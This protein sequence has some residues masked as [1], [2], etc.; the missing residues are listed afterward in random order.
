MDRRVLSVISLLV[1][2]LVAII[3]GIV[4]IN[5]IKE[6]YAGPEFQ[7]NIANAASYQLEEEMEIAPTEENQSQLA[8]A[9]TKEKEAI[10]AV[11]AKKVVI[12]YPKIKTNL[13]SWGYEKASNRKIDTIIV[14]SVY[15]A[16]GDDPFDLEGVLK[17][18]KD[19]EVSSHYII[20]RRGNIYQL[21]K[22]ENIAYHA[23]ASWVPDGRTGANKFSLGI[24]LINDEDHEPTKSQYKSLKNLI[25][26]MKN[27]YKIKY[28]LGHS[29][30]ASSR[31]TDPWNFDWNK[32][33]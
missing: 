32:I 10:L 15:D 12:N 33:N 20:D 18:F 7:L 16:L 22:E 26:A 23:G 4:L 31:K 1:I 11:P 21:V 8:S 3:T 27:R 2:T 28:V 5:S 24:E 25:E 17:E 29:D 9:I 14:H 6:T 19:Y 30:V 13:V